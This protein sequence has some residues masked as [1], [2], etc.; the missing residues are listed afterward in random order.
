MGPI[1]GWMNSPAQTGLR[2]LA[3]TTPVSGLLL[4]GQWTQPGAAMLW[5]AE[6]GIQAARLALGATTAAPPL[7]LGLTTTHP[8]AR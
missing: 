4:A 2:R 8:A 3:P 5:V 6:S 1:Y 7:P